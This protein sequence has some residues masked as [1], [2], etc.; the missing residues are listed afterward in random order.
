LNP[1]PKASTFAN[2]TKPT[3]NPKFAKELALPT[4]TEIK[5]K[6]ESITK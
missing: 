3:R 4:H 6:G 5:E 2:C 1:T